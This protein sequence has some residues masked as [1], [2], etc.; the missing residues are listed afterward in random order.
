MLRLPRLSEDGDGRPAVYPYTPTDSRRPV[1]EERWQQVRGHSPDPEQVE[2]VHFDFKTGSLT[3]LL[4]PL[5]LSEH[6]HCAALD[7]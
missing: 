7:F 4:F 6:L 5:T 1:G 2:F 3:W